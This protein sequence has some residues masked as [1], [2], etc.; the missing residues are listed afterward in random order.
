M[1]PMLLT[2][3]CLSLVKQDILNQFK[4]DIKLTLYNFCSK[5]RSGKY[6]PEWVRFSKLLTDPILNGKRQTEKT[7]SEKLSLLKQ[8]YSQILKESNSFMR[9][10]C[11]TQLKW[12]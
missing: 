11:W 6:L 10:Y 1:S 2:L 7:I 9:T 3:N 4:K 5:F 8:Q 12:G